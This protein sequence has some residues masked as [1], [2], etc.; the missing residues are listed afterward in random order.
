MFPSVL[1]IYGV[2][3]TILPN[4]LVKFSLNAAQ[5]ASIIP[6]LCSR[7]SFGPTIITPSTQHPKLPPMPP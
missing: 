1:F 4:Y 5:Y 3:G 2:Q 7:P 6:D